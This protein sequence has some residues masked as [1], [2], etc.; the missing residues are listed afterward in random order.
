MVID[1]KLLGYIEV[2]LL[3]ICFVLLFSSSFFLKSLSVQIIVA[4]PFNFCFFNSV[5]FVINGNL[6]SLFGCVVF[7]IQ[8][9][10]SCI[11]I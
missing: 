10:V 8:N 3:S 6:F 2:G 9:V 7:R 5:V 4:F 1:Q 11:I